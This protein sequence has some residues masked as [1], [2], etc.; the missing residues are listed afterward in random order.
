MATEGNDGMQGNNSVS[1]LWSGDVADAGPVGNIRDLLRGQPLVP[2][3]GDE[4][5]LSMVVCHETEQL[6]LGMRDYLVLL[7][8]HPH[9]GDGLGLAVECLG[10]D[11]HT[12][13]PE[14]AEHIAADALGFF[15]PL[16]GGVITQ[17]QDDANGIIVQRRPY[18]SAYPHIV[19]ERDDF[20]DATT[21]EP[22]LGAWRAYR[23]QNQRR[24]TRKN[25]MI[26]MALLALEVG[27]SLFP[28]L[29]E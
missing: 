25:R 28:L 12:V 13:R 5:K 16:H 18:T 29:L 26:D 1:P 6:L 3:S 20:Y 21:R 11:P 14:I 15:G 4:R 24:E 19:L 7:K 10:V 8:L 9:D 22:V 2:Y 27:K 17:A 23:I